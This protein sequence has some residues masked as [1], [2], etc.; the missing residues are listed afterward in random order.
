MILMG[1]GGDFLK[2]KNIE[3]KNMFYNNLNGI[4]Q[5]ISMNLV[6][7]FAGLFIKRLNA[8]DNLVSLLNSLP[9]FF[10][11]VAIIFGT[12]LVSSCKNKKR[13]TS[14][15]YFLTRSFYL[16]MALVPFLPQ[17]YRALSFV[18]LYGALNFPGSIANFLWQSFL[19]DTFRPSIR[20]R[21]LS[22][23][24]SLSTITGTVTTLITGFTLASLAS[25]NEKVIS[26]YQ[27]VFAAAFIIGILEVWALYS[28]KEDNNAEFKEVVTTGAN[29][30]FSFVKEAL[31]HKKYTMF[32]IAVICF[33]FA[34]QMGWPLFLT[35]EVET[36]HTNEMWSGI[37]STVS[38]ISMAVG[39]AFWRKFSEKR[40][41]NLAL[42]I[43]A[44]GMATT[45]IFYTITTSIH[46][47]AY[48]T[49]IAGFSTSG[50]LLVLLNTLYEVSP[51]ENRTS[52]IALY[53]LVTNLTLIIAPWIGMRLYQ[54]T[55]MKFALLTV[56]IL[57][58]ASS[59][60]FLAKPKNAIK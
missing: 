33:H 17:N 11:V 2:H 57:R 40:G 53:N 25:S 16:L 4:L 7:S 47:V 20:G 8:G 18:I 24:N 42:A 1:K 58:L 56:G 10:S 37:I 21:V 55:T 54:L 22:I 49:I 3:E 50:I 30:S 6:T 35:Y 28:H 41:N 44:V 26:F 39:Y 60:M 46:Q 19:A 36:L 48:F 59:L 32:L 27:I 9:A 29:L 15:S 34:W 31:T 12:S 45:P 5:V 23:R 13:A 52:Y 14:I 38:G 51:R 43:L